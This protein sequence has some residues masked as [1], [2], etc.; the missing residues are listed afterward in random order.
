[1]VGSADQTSLVGAIPV[2]MAPP[3]NGQRRNLTTAA[4]TGIKAGAGALRGVSVNTGGTGGVITL[5][6]GNFAPVTIDIATPCLIHW[7]GHGLAAG[8]A[9]QFQTSGAL[10]TGLVAG[11]VYFVLAAGLTSGTFQVGATAGGAAIATSGSQSGVQT[12]Y[13]VTNKIGAFSATAQ[14]G[15]PLPQG[16][17]NFAKGL[18]AVTAGSPAADITVYY[19]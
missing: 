7:S 5:Y 9:V 8:D 2:W 13:Q 4:T 14:G 6:D 11:T 10:P 12:G 16:G 17:D 18:I 3:Q 1:M 15:V 19:V